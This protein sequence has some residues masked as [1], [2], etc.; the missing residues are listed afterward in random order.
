MQHGLGPAN[1][2]DYGGNASGRQKRPREESALRQAAKLK[3]E[4]LGFFSISACYL[5]IN[6]S[7]V[8]LRFTGKGKQ[9]GNGEK[10]AAAPA[11]EFL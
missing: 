9:G 6:V 10:D 8:K 11:R 3:G 5:P 1:A 7:T 4:V 2:L